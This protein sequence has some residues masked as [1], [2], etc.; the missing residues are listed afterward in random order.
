MGSRRGIRAISASTIQIEFIY[1]GVRCRERIKLEPTPRNMR[2]AANFRGAILDA[3]ERGTFEYREFFPNSRRLRQ[4]VPAGQL[5]T[6]GAALDE[7]LETGEKSLNRSTWLDY[8]NSVQNKLKPAF[9]GTPLADL[10]RADI[11]AWTA[12]QSVSAKRLS[13][14]LLPLRAVLADAT[15][16]GVITVNPLYGWSPKVKG[17]GQAK[18]SIDPF[19]PDEIHAIVEACA[20]DGIR[21]LLQFAFWTG[22]RTSELIAVRWEDIDGDVLHVCRAKV[23][24]EIKPPKTTSGI[25]KLKLLKPAQ[26]AL[27]AQKPLTYFQQS[28]IFLTPDGK[29]WRDDAHIRKVAWIPTLKKAGVRYR[30]PYQTRHTFASLMCSAGEN[31]Q[32]LATQMGHKDAS[33]V[34]RVYGKWIPDVD[35]HAGTK[36]EALWSA[37]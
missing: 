22:L 31:I 17:I 19:T 7:Y 10:T 37:S 34:N 24:G 21:N 15:A 25:R 9:G 30:Y 5:K 33:M 36:G 16:D 4:F 13:N 8:R 28:W 3:I 23:R 1:R 29:P 14:V 35:P 26:E 27:K 6:V 11:K 12:T 32:W 2:Y 18:T 20:H